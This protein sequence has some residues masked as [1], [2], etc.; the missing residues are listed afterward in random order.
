[1]VWPPAHD[2]DGQRRLEVGLGQPRRVQVRLEVVHPDVREVGGE[3]DRLRRAD[4]DEQRAGEAGP[5]ARGD[6]VEV[7][8]LDARLDERFGDHRRDQLHV[9]TARDLGH[10]A[11]EARVEIDLARHDRRV[12]E[13]TVFHDRGRGLVARRLDA[14]HE[15]HGRLVSSTIVSPGTVRSIEASSS[16]Y[17]GWSTSCTVITSASSLTSW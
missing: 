15:G 2:E 9:G 14:E 13:A 3:R 10:H 12:D 6:R 17:S 1:M 7:G 11:A 16:A 8:E 4:P 5:V